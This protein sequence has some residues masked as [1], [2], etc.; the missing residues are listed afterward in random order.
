MFNTY[1]KIGCLVSL[2]NGVDEKNIGI[3]FFG[4]VSFLFNNEW[5]CYVLWE[6]YKLGW[7]NESE[8]TFLEHNEA[9]IQRLSES[10]EKT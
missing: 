5:R 4:Y 2:N 3:I 8:L 10:V 6:D 1:D 9:G 7:H